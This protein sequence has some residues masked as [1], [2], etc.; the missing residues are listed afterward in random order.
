[1][2]IFGCKIALDV[3]DETGWSLD[4]QSRICNNLYNKLLEQ[5]NHLV[6]Q[7]A[8]SDGQDKQAAQTVYSKRGLRDLVPGLKKD[9]PYYR[10]VYS[11]PLKNT[12]FR[13]RRAIKAHQ[14]YKQGKRK[15]EVGW[16]GFRSWKKK[17]FSLEYDEPWKGYALAGRSLTLSLGVNQA[18]KR[19]RVKGRLKERLPHPAHQV[20]ALRLVKEMGQFYAVF[21]IDDKAKSPLV[22]ARRMA[23]IDPNHKNLGYLFDLTGKAIE[24]D[25]MPTLKTLDRRIDELKGK[26]DRCQ[27]QSQLVTFAR[28]DGSLH[29]H[30]KPSRRWRRYNQSLERLTRLRREQTKT[31]LFTLAK[32]CLESTTW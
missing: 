31:F 29:Q 15:D 7:Y 27:R 2:S 30:W 10:A 12:A 8:Q 16:P 17:W 23:Y 14:D 13:L 9:H 28:E 6:A 1:M 26:R 19:L 5:A 25:N 22:T 18:G 3:T 21:T 24:I 32:A 20:K 4:G 11:S